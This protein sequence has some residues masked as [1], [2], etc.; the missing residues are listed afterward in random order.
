MPHWRRLAIGIYTDDISIRAIVNCAA[1]RKSKRFP[2]HADLAVIRRWRN[3]TKVKLQAVA[4]R[5]PRPQIAGTLRGDI[6][7]YLSRVTIASWKSR[8]SDLEAWIALYGDRSRY[9]ITLE[10]VRAA[11]KQWQTEGRVIGE[12]EHG[13][14]VRRP[15]AAW[16][17]RHRVNA[18]RDLYKALDGHGAPTPVDGL[19]LQRPTSATPIFVT[20]QTIQTVAAQIKNPQTRARFM[21]LATTGVR[22]S[23]LARAQRGDV[24][25]KHQLYSVRTAKGGLS[26]V[27]RLNTPEMRAAWKAFIA[28]DAWGPYDTSL[29]AKRLRRAG[30]PEG[31][32][33]Y[34]LRGTWGMELSRRGADLA[35]IQPLMGHT[36]LRTTRQFYVPPED[37]RLAQATKAT[38]G[39]LRWK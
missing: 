25:L 21:V 3:E 32:R 8:R 34:A 37:S 1:G 39:R 23:E 4:R 16:T 26:R 33:P 24:D 13:H 7:D 18:L 9:R 19:R 12:D 14:E 10:D 2:L 17:I 15:Y 29:H 28:A 31:V 11:V 35:D 20:P 6:T 38:A 30:W 5:H 36:D 22:P 27:L